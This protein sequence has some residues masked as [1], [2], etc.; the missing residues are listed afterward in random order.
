MFD[1]HG[2]SEDS[3]YEALGKLLL[4]YSSVWLELNKTLMYVS[5]PSSQS[6]ES[7]DGQTGESQEGEDQGESN[8]NKKGCQFSSL[9]ASGASLHQLQVIST[10]RSFIRHMQKLALPSLTLMTAAQAQPSAAL[11]LSSAH[12]CFS[13]FFPSSVEVH[14]SVSFFAS[15]FCFSKLC[16]I[17]IQRC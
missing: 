13:L 15:Y 9:S 10:S 16:W 7:G 1:P 14:L 11:Q 8:N 12:T 5:Y 6:P 3:Y 4:L 17:I 2:W